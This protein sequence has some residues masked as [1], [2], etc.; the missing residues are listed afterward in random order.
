MTVVS[1][2]MRRRVLEETSSRRPNGTDD[3]IEEQDRKP[4]QRGS[5]LPARRLRALLSLLLLLTCTP[6]AGLGYIV[7]TKDGYSIENKVSARMVVT[8]I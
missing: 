4:G 6:R 2:A 1:A 8:K 3:A 5:G 7:L